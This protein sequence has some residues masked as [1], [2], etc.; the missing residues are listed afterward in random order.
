MAATYSFSGGSPVNAA[1]RKKLSDCACHGVQTPFLAAVLT[2]S[3]WSR[4]WRIPSKLSR[5]SVRPE[6]TVQPPSSCPPQKPGQDRLAHCGPSACCLY[7]FCFSSFQI[8]WTLAC[9]LSFY[10][11]SSSFLIHQHRPSH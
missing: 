4:Q 2:Q 9:S 10:L 5:W 6:L 1:E 3:A 8:S 11:L 7:L